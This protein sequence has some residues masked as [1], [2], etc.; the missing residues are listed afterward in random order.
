[1]LKQLSFGWQ[2]LSVIGQPPLVTSQALLV[3]LA[4]PPPP[5]ARGDKAQNPLGHLWPYPGRSRPLGMNCPSNTGTGG[6]ELA[7]KAWS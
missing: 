5:L 7:I 3:D 2:L 6:T 1:M 4:P